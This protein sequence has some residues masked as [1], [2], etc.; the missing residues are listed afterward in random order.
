MVMEGLCNQRDCTV[1][2]EGVMLTDPI[3]HLFEELID[4]FL[5]SVVCGLF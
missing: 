3:E 1:E 5:G 4:L 2:M